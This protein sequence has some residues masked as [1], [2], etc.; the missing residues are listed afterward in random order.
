MSNCVEPSLDTEQCEVEVAD[1]EQMDSRS[2]LQLVNIH[3]EMFPPSNQNLWSL[4]E[5]ERQASRNRTKLL[6]GAERANA[7]RRHSFH[8]S[9]F[10]QMAATE[11]R[12]KVATAL[13]V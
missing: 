8:R 5:V 9:K 7:S 4:V 2:N 13:S 3:G 6:E 1:L 11:P 10:E 12:V